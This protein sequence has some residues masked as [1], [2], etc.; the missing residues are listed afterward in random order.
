M[1][2]GIYLSPQASIT[3]LNKAEGIRHVHYGLSVPKRL[4]D[5]V[6]WKKSIMLGPHLNSYD[7]R[8]LAKRE[9]VV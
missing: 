6:R 7:K 3:G 2:S 8:P 1:Y 4:K 9:A 5:Q